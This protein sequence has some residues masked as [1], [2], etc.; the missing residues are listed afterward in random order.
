[1][2]MNAAEMSQ[3]WRVMEGAPVSREVWRECGQVLDKD[4]PHDELVF[5]GR[6]C[7]E[8]WCQAV[9]LYFSDARCTRRAGKGPDYGP[10]DGQAW[11]DLHGSRV[12]LRNLCE[13]LGADVDV[14]GDAM[15]EM[16]T[17]P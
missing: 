3:P 2:T 10:D 15:L 12:M 16:L 14:V 5:Q 7:V 8:L 6:Q 4:M 1:M 9:K 17:G 13:P 11:R